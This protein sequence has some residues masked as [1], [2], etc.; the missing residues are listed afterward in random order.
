MTADKVSQ[1][2][3]TAAAAR[4][5]HL[6][7]DDEPRI[8]ADPLAATLLGERAEELIAYHRLHG[9]H[10]VLASAR[11]QVV[12]RARYAEAEVARLAGRGVTQYVI[13]GAGLDTFAFR[14]EL[15]GKVRT[16]EVDHP[17]SQSWKRG[18]LEAAGLIPPPTLTFVAADFEA[19]DVPAGDVP[20]GGPGAGG[21]KASGA[22]AGRLAGAGLDL[23]Q[24]ALVSWL[25]VTM[26]L[27]RAA[28]GATLAQLGQLAAGTEL[29]CDYLLPA[30]L[31][32]TDGNTYAEQVGPAAAAQGEPWLTELTPDEMAGLLKR[33]GFAVAADVSQREQVDDALWRRSDA[34][35]PIAFSRITRAVLASPASR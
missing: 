28:I 20:A 16:F 11:A 4:A 10:V 22:L 23:S 2:A 17:A 31:R 19:G 6:I 9:D 15:A 27:S 8:L 26:Y 25:G 14:S 29:I 21:A 34:L 30:S 7:V 33:H 18:R 3:L 35:R 5:A 12:C 13:L 32:D 24:P 1:T